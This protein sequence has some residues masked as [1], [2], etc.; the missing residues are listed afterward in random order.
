M[1]PGCA[2][3]GDEG[4]D[5]GIAMGTWGGFVWGATSPPHLLGTG[6]TQGDPSWDKGHGDRRHS[7][8]PP[9]PLTHTKCPRGNPAVGTE[10]RGHGEGW[11]TPEPQGSRSV[12]SEAGGSGGLEAAH[13][14][15]FNLGYK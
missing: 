1:A 7:S 14:I 9:S 3:P 10:P 2:S 15:P 5:A 11:G 6:D 13:L 12:R 4:R 8:V